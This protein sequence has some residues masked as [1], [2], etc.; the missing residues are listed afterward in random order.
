MI[1]AK[2][3][4]IT[5]ANKTTARNNKKTVGTLTGKGETMNKTFKTILDKAASLETDA[6]QIQAEYLDGIERAKQ[7][8][9]EAEAAKEAAETEE[10][11]DKATD[12]IV[13]AREKELFFLRKLE[14]LKFTPRMDPDEYDNYVSLVS[15]IVEKAAEDYRATARK[16]IEDLA[17]A[18]AAYFE[19]GADASKVLTKLD[20]AANVLQSKHRY[21]ERYV[22]GEG[23]KGYVLAGRTEDPGE[24]RRHATRYTGDKLCEIATRDEN[25]TSHDGFGNNSDAELYDIW[26][27]VNNILWYRKAK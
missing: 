8:Q 10:D 21:R 1:T 2:N 3:K 24:W 6:P 16:A 23:G 13:H 12:D 9:E 20:E 4:A 14:G 5:P 18:Q 19:I 15:G 11:F 22:T 27:A 25:K 17:K 26:K 7:A